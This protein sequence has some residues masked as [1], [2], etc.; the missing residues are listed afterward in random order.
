MIDWERTKSEFHIDSPDEISVKRRPRVAVICDGCGKS[1]TK[2]MRH[3]S[4]LEGNWLCRKCAMNVPETKE[5]VL[6]AIAKFNKREYSESTK[7]KFSQSTK[8]NWKD[9]S[10]RNNISKV[11]SK[12]L[13]ERWEDNEFR[14]FISSNSKRNW[15]RDDYRKKIT[16]SLAKSREQM[17]RTSGIQKILY[18][19]LDDLGIKHFREHENNPSDPECQIGPYSF[20]CVIPREGK[21]D[22]LVEC[23]GDYWHSLDKTSSNDNRK[24]SY[25]INNLS[26]QYEIRYV[27]EHEFKCREKIVE[28]VKYWL[29]ITEF[30]IVDYS[31]RDVEIRECPAKDY[32]LL[33]AKYHYL[34]NAGRGGISFGAYFKDELIAVCVFSP[35]GRQNLPWDKKTTKELSRLCVHPRYQKKNFASWFVSRCIKAL[36]P[37]Y[38][39]IISYCDTTF[40]HDGAVYKACNFKLDGEVKPDYWYVAEDGWVMHKRTLYGHAVRMSM[41][42]SDYATHLGYKKVYGKKK[43]RFIYEC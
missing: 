35:L 10:Y 43:L 12:N 23:Q 24:F 36:N 6:K 7:K 31:F 5:R 22:L 4:D 1:G 2:T 42:E 32:R 8:K 40:D 39:T 18:S 13:K 30:E 33:L 25:I 34:P 37:Q 38:K 27:W 28:L 16:A 20:D 41:K 14:G 11:A 9:E 26:D 21:P 29:S 19:V 15:L 3:S 17:P